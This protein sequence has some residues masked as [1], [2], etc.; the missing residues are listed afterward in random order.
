MN[1]AKLI[2]GAKRILPVLEMLL[3]YTEAGNENATIVFGR[4]AS[5]IRRRGL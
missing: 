3:G 4:N 2:R 1:E 5:V